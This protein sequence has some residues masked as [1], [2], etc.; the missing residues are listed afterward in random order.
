MRLGYL[1][2]TLAAL[3][4]Y[5]TASYGNEQPI[6]LTCVAQ[7][8]ET[9]CPTVLPLA[10]RLTFW[11]CE[12]NCKYHCMQAI[13]DKA[14]QD[15][16]PV[17]QY[18]GKWPFYRWMGMQEP[19]SVLFSIGNGLVYLYYYRVLQQQIPANYFM[20][21]WLNLY[22]ILGM[23]AW[24]WSTVFHAR[25]M[26]WTEKMDYFSAGLLILFSCYFALLRLFYVKH[27]PWWLVV[28]FV[29]C[30]AMHVGYL[31]LWRFDYGY[32]MMASVAVGVVQL[33]LWVVW[34]IR[35]YVLPSARRGFA[36]M[37]FL[38]V[39]G[40]SIAMSLELLDFPP[41]ARVLD[42]HSLWHC[43]TI[44]LNILWF[45]FVLRDTQHEMRH[46]KAAVTIPITSSP[47]K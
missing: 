43:S 40:V 14:L 24:V 42:A 8:K 38:S 6:Y 3:L 47:A 37:A 12:D 21:K 16:T 25:D 45:R 20:R 15:G 5:T 17:Y 26:P 27:A 11:S 41:I 19:A 39:V 23:N 7:C 33:T 30:Y 9:H 36:Y 22:T 4:P 28:P 46:N 29:A 2:V 10:L 31:S 44:P 1:L 13:T 34:S 18:H 32:N 35:Q